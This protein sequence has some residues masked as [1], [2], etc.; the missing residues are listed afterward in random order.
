MIYIS[1]R[2]NLDGPDI[3]YENNPAQIKTTLS[4][5]FDCE[6]DAWLINNHF[7]LGHDEPR[8]A[9]KEGFLENQKLWCHAKNLAALEKMLA[10][11]SIHCFWHNQDDHTITSKGYIWTFP[12]KPV[13]EKSVI[14]DLGLEQN[15]AANC[16]GICTDYPILY[17]K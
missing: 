3:S 16:Y 14:V 15:S 1:H 7:F 6:I 10:N 8:Y 13:T 17:Q 5:G 11:D 2:G 12:G 4:K 9:I